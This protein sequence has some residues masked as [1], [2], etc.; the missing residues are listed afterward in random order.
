MRQIPD[1][2]SSKA[3]ARAIVVLAKNLG[4][5]V[6]VE[7]VE[8][9]AQLRF[10]AAMGCEYVQGYFFSKPLPAQQFAQFLRLPPPALAGLAVAR[11]AKADSTDS[12]VMDGIVQPGAFSAS[13]HRTPA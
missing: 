8:T 2:H 7:G 6:I 11:A 9:A 4:L 13:P 12:M 1:D 3:I 5:K 10:F